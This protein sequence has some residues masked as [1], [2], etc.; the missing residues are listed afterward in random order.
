[1]VDTSGRI[2]VI[3]GGPMGKIPGDICCRDED[4]YLLLSCKGH[5]REFED[6]ECAVDQ[7]VE[8]LY[9]DLAEYLEKKGR[10]IETYDTD[11]VLSELER[12]VLR[13]MNKKMMNFRAL[14]GIA[15]C[16]SCGVPIL[17][18]RSKCATCAGAKETTETGDGSSSYK[19]SAK[20]H[21]VKM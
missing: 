9:D 3:C 21:V 18:G 4:S 12:R 19:A 6:R 13:W 1:M 15:F 2:C 7:V 16:A 17:A 11:S 8:L 14:T 10:N 5:L 20:P